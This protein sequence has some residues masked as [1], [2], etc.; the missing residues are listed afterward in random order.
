[1]YKVFDKAKKL[2]KEID[3]ETALKYIDKVTKLENKFQK[4]WNFDIDP[5]KHIW[6]NRLPGCSCPVYDN[7]ERFGYP[8]I[9]NC[10]CKFHKYLCDLEDV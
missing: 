1:M 5:L 4:N 7:Q 6:W 2:P 10:T 8:K 3:K 9:L